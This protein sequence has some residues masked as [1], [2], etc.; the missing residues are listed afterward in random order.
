MRERRAFSLPPPACQMVLGEA[1][2]CGS[3]RRTKLVPK[4]EAPPGREVRD[5]ERLGPR[6]LRG[7]KGQGPW[8]EGVSFRGRRV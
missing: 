7:D 2:G 8:M 6:K 5:C 3:G 4:L 1:D